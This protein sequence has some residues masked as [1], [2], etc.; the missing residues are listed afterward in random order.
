L[1]LSHPVF[2]VVVL[3][4]AVDVRKPAANLHYCWVKRARSKRIVPRPANTPGGNVELY[5]LEKDPQ[6]FKNLAAGHPDE[7]AALRKALD[8]WWSP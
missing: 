8:A 3:H 5:D 1:W 4:T 7:V 2:I 6:E